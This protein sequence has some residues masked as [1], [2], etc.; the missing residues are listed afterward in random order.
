MELIMAEAN[1]TTTPTKD[2]TQSEETRE[3]MLF[4]LSEIYEKLSHKDQVWL[5]RVIDRTILARQIERQG[6]FS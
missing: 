2:E 6:G 1:S 3:L 5:T 4:A